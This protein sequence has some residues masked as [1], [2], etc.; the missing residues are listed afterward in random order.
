MQQLYQR[1]NC[2][3]EVV[4]ALKPGRN[5]LA[6]HCHDTGGGGAGIDAR[7]FLDDGGQGWIDRLTEAIDE[8][9]ANV[10]LLQARSQAH[11]EQGDSELA[12]A[13]AAVLLQ[14]LS[15]AV[16]A[17]LNDPEVVWP[18]SAGLLADAL[19]ASIQR[20][21]S[22]DWQVLEIVDMKSAGGATLTRLDNGSVLGWT[23][24]QLEAIAVRRGGVQHLMQLA[25]TAGHDTN[26]HLS[27]WLVSS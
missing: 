5:V 25:G 18:D 24:R 6:I 22:S 14:M 3:A 9:P 10:H 26:V 15:D 2:S 13:D 4:A 12:A 1:I 7:L 17:D 27:G 23:S 20:G 8:D 16:E 19:L 21:E 11:A